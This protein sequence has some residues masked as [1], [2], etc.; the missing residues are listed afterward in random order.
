[1]IRKP[2][3]EKFARKE[4]GFFRLR[5]KEKKVQLRVEKKENKDLKRK[6][7]E[8]GV[9]GLLDLVGKE[10]YVRFMMENKDHEMTLP[11]IRSE[12]IKH[13]FAKNE[14]QANVLMNQLM[15]GMEF[16]SSGHASLPAEWRIGV[17]LEPVSRKDGTVRWK[18]VRQLHDYMKYR[19]P[20][21]R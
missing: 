4:A 1:M 11:Q 3:A 17:H 5:G 8:L 6:L 16:G 15:K 18:L 13:G 7:T 19:A 12:F 10:K 9:G 2:L 14:V 21:T 20:R